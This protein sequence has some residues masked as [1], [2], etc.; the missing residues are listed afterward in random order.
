MRLTRLAAAL[1]L[2]AFAAPA[3]AGEKKPPEGVDFVE[4]QGRVD[5][6]FRG[7]ALA[8]YVYEDKDTLR[9]YFTHV[10][11]PDGTRVTRNHPPDKGKD[12]TDH[13]TFHPGAWLAFGDLN[14]ADNWRNKARV[15]HERFLQKPLAAPDAVSF[16]VL[17]TY[18][19]AAG[20]ELCK[21]ECR[22][23]VA[24]RGNS[25]W[26]VCEATFRSEKGDLA[27]GDQEEMGFGVRLATPLAV[28]KGG[29]ILNSGGH[30]NEKGAWGKQADW[31]DY[32]GAVGGK[33]AGV[34]LMPSPRN[35]RASW[36]HARDY[37]LLV[38]NPFGRNAF[39]RGEP[40]R[41]VVPQGL[42]FHL[43]FAACFYSAEAREVPDP[44]ALYQD[45]L[46]H[47]LAKA[48]APK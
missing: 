35:F 32:R 43:G 46:K 36:F 5:V 14:G 12:L 40:S 20:K 11:A 13:A 39:T 37:G 29:R 22:W 6:R 28:V 42:P 17:D 15:R 31:C 26:L 4:S 23:K 48:K 33:E 21:A 1:L 16:T 44:A 19:D 18:L 45:Y 2:C 27:F 3:A 7:K 24:V 9:P 8:G 38:A 30:K 25:T 41:V 10:H 34:T 47:F